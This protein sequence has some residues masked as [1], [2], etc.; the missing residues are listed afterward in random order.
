MRK[1]LFVL[2]T[3]MA[4]A[5][6]TGCATKSTTTTESAT[7]TA[8]AT[9]ATTSVE[10]ADESVIDETDVALETV[11][12]TNEIVGGW[13]NTESPKLTDKVKGYFAEAF[14]DGT[15]TFYEPVAFLGT[16]VV[17]GTNYKILYRKISIG[18]ADAVDTYGIATIYVDLQNNVEVLD[19][20]ETGI[21]THLD[22]GSW[23]TYDVTDLT[24]DEKTA[25]QDAFNGMTGVSYDPIAVIAESDKGY[26]V[27]FEAQVVY[28]GTEPYYAVVEINKTEAGNLEIGEIT[29]LVM[30]EK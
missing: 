26:Y 11:V 6:F 19:A 2:A 25:F 7:S 9:E 1:F 4:A 3:G 22:E 20:G 23:T 15:T 13:T 21:P 14:P 16:Q 17:S 30:E 27:L 10:T 18:G 5:S 24:D 28:P 29:D 8:V 12:A